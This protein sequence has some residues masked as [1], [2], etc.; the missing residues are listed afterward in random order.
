MRDAENEGLEKTRLEARYREREVLAEHSLFMRLLI[1]AG[2]SRRLDQRASVGAPSYRK[3][4][5]SPQ[6]VSRRPSAVLTAELGSLPS[7]GL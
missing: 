5:P 1:S 3:K 2:F 7:F 4:A 6:R